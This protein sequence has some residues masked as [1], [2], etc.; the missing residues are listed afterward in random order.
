[1]DIDEMQREL[2]RLRALNQGLLNE[3]HHRVKNNLQIM[4]NLLNL[5]AGTVNSEEAVSA[6][7]DSQNRLQAM[8]LIHQKLYQEGEVQMVDMKSF[9]R[10]FISIIRESF[11]RGSY[12]RLELDLVSM[13][14]DIT[15]A[16]PLA[17]ILNEAVT[18]V[19]K[20]AFSAS[21][22]ESVL[23]LT[24]QTSYEAGTGMAEMR[25][26]DNGRGFPAGMDPDAVDTLGVRLMRGLAEQMYG[27]LNMESD[28]GAIVRIVFRPN[29]LRAG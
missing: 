29:G 7:R 13:Q 18:N 27:E 19:Y 6:I 9:I 5:E 3:L 23:I 25:I 20:Y 26:R 2:E 28:G 24:V 21:S 1:M 22:E 14:L 8:A 12:V 4:M 11:Y 10:E 17:L 15:Q 16:I